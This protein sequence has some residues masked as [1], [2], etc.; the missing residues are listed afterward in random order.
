MERDDGCDHILSKDDGASQ[1]C[2][3][4]EIE[5]TFAQCYSENN[6]LQWG[7]FGPISKK[8]SPQTCSSLD[9]LNSKV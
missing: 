7:F 9:I 8:I 3:Q 2:G 6:V 5:D 4:R 1:S